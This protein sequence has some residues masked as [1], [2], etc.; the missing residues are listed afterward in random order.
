VS[1]PDP[2]DELRDRV[3]HLECLVASLLNGRRVHATRVWSFLRS[4]PHS[5]PGVVLAVE[6]QWMTIQLDDGVEVKRCIEDVEV[7]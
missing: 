4:C 5:G 7:L 3:E 6:G 1:Y 2:A